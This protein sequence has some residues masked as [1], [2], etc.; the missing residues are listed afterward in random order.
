MQRD[1]E[2]PALAVGADVG[3]LVEQRVGVGGPVEHADLPVALPARALL[4][5]VDAPVGREREADRDVEGLVD[6]HRADLRARGPGH[7]GERR[8]R[9]EEPGEQS[10]G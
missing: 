5:V 9:S 1:A 2:H 6:R 4:R 7:Q 8:E 3:E 10:R